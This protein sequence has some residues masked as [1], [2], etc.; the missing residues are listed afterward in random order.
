[1]NRESAREGLTTRVLDLQASHATPIVV[2]LPNQVEVDTETQKDPFLKVKLYYED[3]YQASIGASK[4]LRGVGNLVLEC[5]VPVG[6][7]VKPANDILT[8]FYEG[9][10]MTDDISGVRTMATKFVRCYQS[11]GWEVTPV[12]IPFWYDDFE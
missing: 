3:S 7:G 6:K 1:M 11:S 8:H 4:H 9:L 5:W 12:L 10:H 2:Q